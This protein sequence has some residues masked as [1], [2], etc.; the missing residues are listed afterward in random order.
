MKKNESISRDNGTQFWVC[1]GALVLLLTSILSRDITRPFY[2]IHSWAEAHTPWLARVQIRNGFSYTKGFMTWSVGNPPTQNPRRY[3][4]HPQLGSLINAAFMAVLGINE[5]ALR[6]VNIAATIITLLLF[7]KILKNL[8]DEKTA[9]LAGLLFCL[10]PVIGY[11][12]AN[13]WPYPFALWAL[14]NY[15]VIIRG[16]KENIQ[17]T[18]WHIMALALCLF[19]ILQ[20]SWEG[21]FFALGIGVHYV[22]RCIRRKQFPDK[23]LL[24]TLTA[25]PLSSLALD[26][27]IMAIGYGNWQKI[28]DL[29]KWRAGSGEMA[30]HV[31][32]E[33]F[34][35]LWELATTNFT[36][37]ILLTVIVY[38]TVGQMLILASK[39]SKDKEFAGRGFPHFWLFSLPAIFQLFILKG[40]LWKHQ[41]WE[42][43]LCFPIAIAGAAGVMLLGDIVGKINKRLANV[44]MILLVG[45]FFI[46]SIMGTNYYYNI[47]WQQPAKIEMFKFLSQRIPPDKGLLSFEDFI[48]RQH[49]AKGDFYRPEIAWHLD[50]EIVQATTLAEVESYA[51][52]G[53]YPCYLVPAVDELSFL[54]SELRK[55]YQMLKYIPGDPGEQKYGRFYKAGMPTYIIFDLNSKITGQ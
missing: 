11:F 38:L 3:L 21:F 15:L 30:Q 52:T 27:I 4:D 41:T 22:F 29:W 39:S 37:P 5:W 54:V 42:R 19:M 1:A 26:F 7:L 31:W 12:G 14:W 10:F 2:G 32:S 25:A 24:T 23:V 36:L 53:K 6:V 44:A 45:V 18:K 17:P 33:W 51:K 20:L 46:A 34:A 28:I 47:R 48:V 8:T 13:L 35:K 55:R 49:P 16:L 9:L 50:R 40:C 43:P